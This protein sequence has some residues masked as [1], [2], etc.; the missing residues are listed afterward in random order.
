[1]KSFV[2]YTAVLL[3]AGAW[4][5]FLL[6]FILPATLPFWLGLVIA[7]VL[8]PAILFFSRHMRLRRRRAAAFVTLVFYCLLCLLA[9]L[10]LT[11][12]WGQLCRLAASFPSIYKL[13]FIPALAN[14]FEWLSGF[15]SR[16]T[17]DLAG[18][19]HLLMQRASAISAKA[20][21]LISSALL[22]A[23][24]E[25][26][27][28]LP[29]FFLTAAVTVFCSAFISL[30]Y[31]KVSAFLLSL[32]PPRLRPM[33][34]DVKGFVCTTL[35][36]TIKAYLL[37]LLITFAELCIGLWILRVEN[38]IFA[39]ALIA[40]LDLL[41]IIGTGTAIIPWAIFS[42]I[43]GNN[44]LGFG[45]V[46]LYILISLIRNFIEPKLV[47]ESIGLPPLVSLVSI[48]AGLRL[49]GV[50]G[51]LAMPSVVLTIIFV[52]QKYRASPD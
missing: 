7:F 40:L 6:R 37:I 28:K 22:T 42:I 5:L 32:L 3:C 41:P 35:A 12:L 26:A 4:A 43:S 30:D 8:R 36:K 17:P 52:C 16:F 51:A 50:L 38:F 21:S 49:F 47:G 46:V 19:I 48:Y 24:T 29:V 18:G 13:R 1:M 34:Q 10:L 39:A 2:L 33:A 31:P 25:L 27:A 45:L 11:F 9:W 15:L 20:S 23:C 14:F 44:F